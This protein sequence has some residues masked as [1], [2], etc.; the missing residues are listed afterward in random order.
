VKK[1]YRYID[2]SEEN[3]NVYLYCD[4]RYIIGIDDE[5]LLLINLPNCN[6]F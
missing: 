1:K 5:L 3:I 2:T 6:I 4:D